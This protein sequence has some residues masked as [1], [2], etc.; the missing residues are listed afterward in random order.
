MGQP[1]SGRIFARM[2][3]EHTDAGGL[4]RSAHCHEPRNF[5]HHILALSGTKTADG[6]VDPKLVLS[7]L[8][9]ELGAGAGLAGLLVPLR[10]AGALL[11]QIVIAGRIH[12]LARRK[13][14]WAAGAAVQGLAAV[15]MIMAALL[16][17]GLLAGMVIAGALAILALARAACSV[18][19][20]DVLGKT[21]GKRRRGTVT[22]AAAGI[23]SAV[24]VVFAL[25]L[26]GDVTDRRGLVLG[27]LGVGA[28]GWCV[29]AVAMATLVEERDAHTVA[30]YQ[31]HPLH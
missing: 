13:W 28:M 29:A 18:S 2:V 21:V 10:E 6:L 3:G 4:S 26:L 17:N 24:V 25:L 31:A 1:L 30:Q 15:V 14:V 19:Y 7:W 23:G 11:P 12:R 20:K 9:N 8:V 5:C 22:G 16:L 27:A